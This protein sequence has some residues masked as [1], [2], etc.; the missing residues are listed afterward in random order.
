MATAA[1]SAVDVRPIALRI[2]AKGMIA[3]SDTAAETV[4]GVRV[5]PPASPHGGQVG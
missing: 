1:E 4:S 2:S 3:E 5:P